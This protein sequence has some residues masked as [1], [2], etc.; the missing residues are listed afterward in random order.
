MSANA[1]RG[2]LQARRFVEQLVEDVALPRRI[3]KIGNTGPDLLK[4]LQSD[5]GSELRN[6]LLS[7]PAAPGS[8]RAG[9]G[10]LSLVLDKG[11]R[12]EGRVFDVDT[13]AGLSRVGQP[14]GAEARNPAS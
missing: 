9:D 7:K 8:V 2:R 13:D 10:K 14:V 3:A 12:L 6:E 4:R 1:Q 11:T 5:R